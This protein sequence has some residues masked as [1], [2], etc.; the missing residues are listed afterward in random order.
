MTSK[1][2]GSEVTPGT[3]LAA[4]TAVAL[5]R[6]GQSARPARS[7]PPALNPA[8]TTYIPP[9]WNKART[10]VHDPTSGYALLSW[11]STFEFG[12]SS[13]LIY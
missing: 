4:L 3:T 1:E 9:C 12:S 11:C 5:A 10:R 13:C 2:R 8:A 7:T 6:T